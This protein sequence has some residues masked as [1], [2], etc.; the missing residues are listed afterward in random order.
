MRKIAVIGATIA[1]ATG[2]VGVVS[3]A[4]A[5]P[6]PSAM[7]PAQTLQFDVVFS[8]FFAVDAKPKGLS[9]GDTSVFHDRL[10][11]NGEA[12]GQQ[13]GTC[14]IVDLPTNP[15][16]P[17]PVSCTVSIQLADGQVTA[18]GLTSTRPHQTTRRHRRH[19][20]LPERRRPSHLSRIRQRS[21][22]HHA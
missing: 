19:R 17:I 2:S 4:S 6:A 3:A 16:E 9:N 21:R 11:S 7:T 15:S 20:H 18:Q 14:V 8:P 13:G 22:Q 12:A 5:T 1:L 10:F